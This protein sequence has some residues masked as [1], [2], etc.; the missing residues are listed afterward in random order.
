MSPMDQDDPPEELGRG[1]QG[2]WKILV[3][4]GEPGK[5]MSGNSTQGCLKDP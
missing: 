1:S 2:G 4:S 5:T 3:G